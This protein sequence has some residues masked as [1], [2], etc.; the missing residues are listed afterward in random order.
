MV[1]EA[2][3]SVKQMAEILRMI[4]VLALMLILP[5]MAQADAFQD[6]LTNAL[7]ATASTSG[8]LEKQL[9]LGGFI[10]KRNYIETGNIYGD[11]SQI[12]TFNIGGN[13]VQID[14]GQAQ[15]KYEVQKFEYQQNTAKFNDYLRNWGSMDRVGK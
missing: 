4:A 10:A 13:P 5:S 3:I 9:D 15:R 1:F 14:L 6:A 12:P 11:R 7:N 2:K 8:A